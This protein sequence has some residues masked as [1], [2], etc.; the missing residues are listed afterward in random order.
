MVVSEAKRE[1]NRRN[2]ARSTGPKSAAGKQRS[3]RNAVTHGLRAE[4]LIMV[5]EDPQ[6]LADRKEAWTASILPRDDVEQSAVNDA[7]DHAWLRDRARR[8][9]AARI[10]AN[11]ANA[12]VDEAKRE[13]DEA[14]R[15]GQKL[16]SDNN[17]PLAAYPHRDAET[18]YGSKRVSE[19]KLVDD[20]EDPQR[21]V[22]HLQ[23][24]ASGCQWML[25]QW[26]DLGT[27]LAKGLNWQS[28]DK[29]KAVRLLGRHPIEAADDPNVLM[30]FLAC[31]TMEGQPITVIPE[32]WNELRDHERKPYARRLVGRGIDRL[33]PESVAAARQVLFDIVERETTQIAA[34]ADAHRRRAE[35]IDALTADCLLFDDSPAGERLRRYELA[36]GRAV[37]RSLDALHK[38]R[39]SSVVSGPLSVVNCGVAPVAEQSA[40]NEPTTS[41]L[42][43]VS[44]PLPVASCTGHATDEP[45]VVREIVTNE[46][47]MTGENA[48][49]EPTVAG[50]IVANEPTV[51]GEIV[52]NEPTVAHENVTSE[53]TAAQENAPNEPTDVRQNA[54]NE[55]IA[56]RENAPNEPT[57]PRENAPN[58]P[59]SGLLSVVSCPLP[60]TSYTAYVV[61]ELESTNEPTAVHENAT[62]EPTVLRQN[63]P[64]EPTVVRHDATNE[65][66]VAHENAPNEPTAVW[67]NAAN[68]PTNVGGQSVDLSAGTGD[69]NERYFEEGFSVQEGEAIL[70]ACERIRLA[71]E[72]EVRKLNEEA[73][74]E[75]EAAMVIRGFRLAEQKNKNGKPAGHPKARTTQPGQTSKKEADAPDL[76]ELEQFAKT[77]LAQQKEAHPP[78]D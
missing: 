31:Q 4:N 35:V 57:A 46:P 32:I 73:R 33:A 15:L 25:D 8:A 42:S 11:I 39:K 74:T 67:R 44:G 14:L 69:R 27:T 52:T 64:D 77:A 63:A 13:S 70:K 43:L 17:G 10:A 62:N 36:N 16:F 71:R 45:T 28:A 72:E 38:H 54:P 48:T 7:V 76:A 60:V 68:E 53:P 21:L 59:T 3:S 24:T 30:V 75:A 6:E 18:A 55:P 61:D 23:A 9:Q 40:T 49:N 51:A 65:P 41:P 50:E 1:A 2:A 56:A 66:T 47:T 26:S 5:D 29:L 19:S 58:E 20:P 78:F 22:L 37:W 12:G 34:K